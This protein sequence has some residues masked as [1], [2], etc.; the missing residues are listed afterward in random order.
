MSTCS[1][2]IAEWMNKEVSYGALAQFDKHSDEHS[3]QRISGQ[4]IQTC[5][6]VGK[7]LKNDVPELRR[8]WVSENHN[9][10]PSRLFLYLWQF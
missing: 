7:L 4:V 10:V 6:D 1:S 9:K 2:E 3:L 8:P 5:R